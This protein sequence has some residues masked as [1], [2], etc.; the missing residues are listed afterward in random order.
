MIRLDYWLKNFA[1]EYG[2]DYEETF[3][4]MARLTTVYSFLLVAA[5]H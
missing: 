5:V 3:A 2:I 4:F 1:Q